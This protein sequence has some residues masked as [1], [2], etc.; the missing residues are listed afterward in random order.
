MD[1]QNPK[2]TSPATFSNQSADR[3]LLARV[4][5]MFFGSLT[6]RQERLPERVRLRM[7]FA[8]LRR[9]AQ[10][11]K[12]FFPRLIWALRQESGPGGRKHFHF[13]LTGL[14][15]HAITAATCSFMSKEW[16][17]VGGG[18]S[19]IALYNPALDGVGYVVKCLWKAQATPGFESAKFGSNSELM[20][21]DSFWAKLK[22]CH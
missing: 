9:I 15:R 2:A 14:P 18:M 16:E 4:D 12:T 19:R 11:E 21:S 5:W 1:P 6:F 10:R 3:Y 7:F 13:L 20:L 22:T 17:H 8:L